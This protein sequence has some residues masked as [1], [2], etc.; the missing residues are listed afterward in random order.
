[1]RKLP[2][3]SSSFLGLALCLSACFGTDD[4]MMGD[5]ETTNGG[6]GD[7]DSGDGDGDSGDG[8]G[9]S[10]DGD[11]DSGDCYEQ[12]PECQQFVNCI[13]ALAPD[14]RAIVEEDYG[15]NGSCWCGTEQD[16]QGCYATC[17]SQLEMALQSSPTEKHCHESWCELEDLDPEQPYGPVVNG[18]CSDYISE[19][20][21][22]ISQVAINGPAG[23]AGHFCSP[24]C[25]GLAN[26][27]PE[28]S[29]TSA[30]G[31]CYLVLGMDNHCIT[32][33]YVDST[34]VG[35]TQCQCG[36]TCRPQGNPDGEGNM[37]GICTFD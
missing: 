24:K 31:T 28:H 33:C 14:Q 11:G 12:P 32:R 36:A 17:L 8:D 16:A 19:Q 22:P 9:D 2:L 1:M 6:D 30:P 4:G 5:E 29:Q 26:Y 25:S 27:C 34:I 20:G 21:E 13:G 37:R 23:V 35:G 7:G 15:A 10:G 18:S 3:I